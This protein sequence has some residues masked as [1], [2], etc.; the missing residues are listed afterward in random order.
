MTNDFKIVKITAMACIIF[1]IIYT[2]FLMD[3]YPRD[4]VP[5]EAPALVITLNS[6]I[7]DEG[8]VLEINSIGVGFPIFEKL[9]WRLIDENDTVIAQ[10]DFPRSS[11]DLGGSEKANITVT[12]FDN[13]ENG[14]LSINDTIKIRGN[15]EYLQAQ[16][17]DI[18]NTN[19]G[20]NEIVFQTV[21]D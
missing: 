20:K 15:L 12:W 17:F 7:E 10:N 19:L 8:F 9:E 6:T 1:L 16:I 21:I 5:E 11:G 3:Y 13:D 18:I 2:A 14:N 4:E